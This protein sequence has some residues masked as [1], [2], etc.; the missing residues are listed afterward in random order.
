MS[1]GFTAEPRVCADCDQPFTLSA[2]EQDW[3]FQRDLTL[4]RRC[5][6]CRRA[7]KAA[8]LEGSIRENQTQR[9]FR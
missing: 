1:E 6:P 9:P 3:F 7:R 8:R 4:S 2:S 5:L